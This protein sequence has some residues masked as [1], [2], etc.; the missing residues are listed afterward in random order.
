[1]GMCEGEVISWRVR[2]LCRVLAPEARD[3]RAADEL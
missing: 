1:M 3:L 2:L